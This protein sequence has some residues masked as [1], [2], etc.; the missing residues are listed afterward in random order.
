[1]KKKKKTSIGRPKTKSLSKA[2]DISAQS[3]L[4][5]CLSPDRETQLTLDTPDLSVELP[6]GIPIPRPA[7]VTRIPIQYKYYVRR[8]KSNNFPVYNVAKRGG[9]QQI[10]QIH[11][12]E[13]DPRVP[14]PPID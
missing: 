1:M 11:H 2:T 12:V 14:P 10:T 4:K 8:T 7:P 5:N 6:N 13:G 3:L 9:S